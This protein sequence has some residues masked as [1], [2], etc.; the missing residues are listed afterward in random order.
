MDI[1][2]IPKIDL[3]CHLD[4]SLTLEMIQRH[5]DKNVTLDMLCVNENCNSLAEYLEKFSLPLECLQD[6]EGLRD[7][8]YSFLREAAKENIQYIEVRFAPMLSVHEGLSCSAVIE[9]VLEGLEKG[10][11][12]FG[13]RY[14]VIT[15]AMRHHNPE[16]NL[17]MLYS[18]REY[19]GNGVCAIDLA[20]DES[21]FPTKQFQE[22]FFK[23]RK[24]EMPFV[25][26][27]GETG[28]LQNVQLAYDL[29][30]SRI[31]H[32]IALIKDKK[33]MSLFAKKKI[34]V[35]MCPSSNLQTKSINDWSE[36]P[37]MDYLDSGIKVSIN[38]D[39]RTVSSTTLTKE[40]MLINDTYKNDN[41][42]YLLL[43]NA[44]ETAF[45]KDLQIY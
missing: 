9:S 40:L 11:N 43:K 5:T 13:V 38:T 36:Y 29:G 22:L 34:G 42:I 30:A 33:L 39:N 3:H 15:C 24:L 18:A 8:A 31:G 32:G 25:I 1:E 26:H 37:L 44:E 2:K 28:N 35:E 45:E 16:Q 27:S 6:K 4:G 10:K 14:N 20:G 41:L 19:L 7:G 21:V 17:Q 12:V 23:A